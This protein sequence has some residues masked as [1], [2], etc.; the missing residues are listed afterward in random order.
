MNKILINKNLQFGEKKKSQT[1]LYWHEDCLLDFWDDLTGNKIHVN[2]RLAEKDR[3]IMNNCRRDR[4]LLTSTH[5]KQVQI[6]KY[7]SYGRWQPIDN[8]K[9]VD[10]RM[11]NDIS[12]TTDNKNIRMLFK[13]LLILT[14]FNIENL[15]LFLGTPGKRKRSL[16]FR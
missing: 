12:V 16:A 8:K 6:K 2:E 9:D 14:M 1:E 3:K 7:N 11:G 13:I 10:V 5:K 15:I 4:N